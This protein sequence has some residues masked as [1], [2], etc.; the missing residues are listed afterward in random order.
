MFQDDS[1]IMEEDEDEIQSYSDSG[2][3]LDSDLLQWY[4]A[5]LSKCPFRKFN[6]MPIYAHIFFFVALFFQTP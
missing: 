5:S 3:K 6:F 4:I 1:S 2:R